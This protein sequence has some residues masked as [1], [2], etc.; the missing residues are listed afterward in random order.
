MSLQGLLEECNPV[1]SALTNVRVI[2]LSIPGEMSDFCR[3][4][5]RA[6]TRVKIKSHDLIRVGL[7]FNM[8]FALFDH[9]R[10]TLRIKTL[11]VNQS[12]GPLREDLN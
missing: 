9:R 3:D 6:L 2:L 12:I 8:V 10:F 5:C 1:A 7:G 4:V 11:P